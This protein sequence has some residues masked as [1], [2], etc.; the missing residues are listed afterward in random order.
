MW[1]SVEINIT[2]VRV[3]IYNM[4]SELKNHGIQSKYLN[5]GSLCKRTVC[6][7][8]CVHGG[9][10]EVVWILKRKNYRTSF[11]SNLSLGRHSPGDNPVAVLR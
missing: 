10:S 6:V 3:C 11:T 1:N 9:R 2:F 5:N 7:C 8:V 4:W